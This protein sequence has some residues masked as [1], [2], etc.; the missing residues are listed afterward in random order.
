MW[1][2][3]KDIPTETLL[4]LTSRYEDSRN[5]LPLTLESFL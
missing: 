3:D 4:G 5:V 2:F 1:D